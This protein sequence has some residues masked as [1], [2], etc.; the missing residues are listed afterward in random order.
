MAR[1]VEPLADGCTYVGMPDESVEIRCV[2]PA[3]TLRLRWDAASFRLI[4]EGET[5]P[6]FDGIELCRHEW[7]SR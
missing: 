2:R 1:F 5:P 3:R 7:D 4:P 6:S